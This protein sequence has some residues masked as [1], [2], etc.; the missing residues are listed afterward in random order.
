M[1]QSWESMSSVTYRRLSPGIY[2]VENGKWH[3][4]SLSYL[5]SSAMS[6]ALLMNVQGLTWINRAACVLI[7]NTPQWLALCGPLGAWASAQW[8]DSVKHHAVPRGTGTTR[9]QATW[10]LRV[11]SGSHSPG[12]GAGVSFASVFCATLHTAA[13]HSLIGSVLITCLNN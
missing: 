3:H 12:P 5:L 10:V 13:N 4:W 9:F 7:V 2:S 8:N 6:V 1:Q 11:H